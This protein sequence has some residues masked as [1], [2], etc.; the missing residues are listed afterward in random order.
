MFKCE[1]CS[2]QVEPRQPVNMVTVETREKNYRVVVITEFDKKTVETEGQEIVKECRACP[3]CFTKKTGNKAEVLPPPEEK[4]E[5]FYKR[6]AP[7]KKKKKKGPTPLVT[8]I[9]SLNAKS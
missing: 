4:K 2:E 8:R 3:E 7:K 5:V 6:Q 1:F 9:K